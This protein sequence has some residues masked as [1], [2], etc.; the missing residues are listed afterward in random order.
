MRKPA[1]H[2]R[3][4]EYLTYLQRFPCCQSPSE[5]VA[6]YLEDVVRIWRRNWLYGNVGY[7]NASKAPQILCVFNLIVSRISGI[8][9]ARP[10]YVYVVLYKG[11]RHN[12]TCPP[13]QVQYHLVGQCMGVVTRLIK[14]DKLFCDLWPGNKLI[15]L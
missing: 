14:N 4:L 10:A 8:V 7:L 6:E 5:S 15:A 3:K 12:Q 2:Y 13:K 11:H 1:G 9:I